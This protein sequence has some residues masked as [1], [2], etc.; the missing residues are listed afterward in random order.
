M[1][2]GN[3]YK[4]RLDKLIGQWTEYRQLVLTRMGFETLGP[5]DERKFLNLKGKIIEGLAALNEQLGFD[6]AQEAQ[7]HVNAISNLLNRFPT[8]YTDSPLDNTA[9][10]EFE[11]EWHSHFLFLNKLKGLDGSAV[12]DATQPGTR[13]KKP[14]GK[15]SR[16]RRTALVLS[17]LG[18][19]ATLG[20]LAYRYLPWRR[21]IPQDQERQTNLGD[22][23]A[24]FAS[25]WDSIVDAFRGFSLSGSF[26]PVVA[27]YGPEV[28]TVLV[29]LLLIALGYW[30]FVRA[31]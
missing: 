19:V 9:R 25:V 27:S 1:L 21:L 29:A 18:I 23:P 26:E 15:V 8:L 17:Q 3:R 12:T 4:G 20:W 31:R 7:A 11:R 14:K 6:T 24:F 16:G 22:I 10:A 30:V 13:P 2:I 5:S 28:T